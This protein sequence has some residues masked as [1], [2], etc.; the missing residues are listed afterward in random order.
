ML[1]YEQILAKFA[2]HHADLELT[3]FAPP[4]GTERVREF[5]DYHWGTSKASRARNLAVARDFFRWATRERGLAGDPTAAIASPR[6]RGTERRAHSDDLVRRLVLGQDDLRD[7][8]A[9]RLLAQ[10]GL[11]K[12]ELRLVQYRHL[13]LAHSM[14]TVFG[15]GGTVLA[16]PLVWADLRLDIER[17]ILERQAQ[18][19]HFLLYP[20]NAPDRPMD[21]AT[22]VHR[23]WTR[24]AD[25]AGLPRFPMH[26]L[27]HTAITAFLRQNGNLKLAQMLARHASISTTADIYG[28]LEFADLAT[29][30][31]GMPAL[32]GDK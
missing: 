8:V 32:F 22:S 5:L 29:A 31:R 15:K 26:E 13:D 7:Q 24:C 16:V 10:L 21:A 14:I 25:R 17:L 19:D 3:D 9:L 4:V 20:K 28:H 12:N 27:R 11:R 23:W 1:V 30:L 2:L 18:P 6:R